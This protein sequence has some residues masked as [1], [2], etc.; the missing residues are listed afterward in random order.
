M[1]GANVAIGGKSSAVFYNPAGLAH[2]PKQ[3]GWE[4]GLVNL[5]LSWNENIAGSPGDMLDCVNQA[6]ANA[7]AEGCKGFL[8]E[9]A[10]AATTEKDSN[11][12]VISTGQKS[13]NVID[14][15]DQYLGQN[16]Y[17]ELNEF[18]SVAKKFDKLGFA[19]GAVGGATMSFEV[20]RGFGSDGVM[21]VESL[22]YGGG[23]L[24]ASYDFSAVEVG[25]IILN[26]FSLGLG[27]KS[28]QYGSI[29]HAFLISELVDD[30]LVDRLDPLNGDLVKLGQSTVVDLGLTYELMPNVNVGAS[31][32]NM[33]GIGDPD[34]VYIPMTV[35]FGL[36]YVY[37]RPDAYFFDRIRVAADY[38]DLTG[39]YDTDSD[40]VKRTRIGV[41]SYVW[42]SFLTA[43]ALRAGM[44]QGEYTAGFDFRLSFLQLGF[45]TY[46]EQVGAA[47]AT[48]IDR[49]YIMNL[50]LGW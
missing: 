18:S 17:F 15:I 45:A 2:I 14:V 24:G 41:E 28:I 49:R 50:S 26:D 44:Y 35:N 1:G 11:G 27:V 8:G 23:V 32:M 34:G 36:G 47:Y 16:F 12:N 39:G 13:A 3:W 38:V 37:E 43:L 20:H 6:T 7:N 48:D 22:G 5:N 30:K 10:S 21:E 29:T 46:A 19:V 40:I 4:F 9:M 25:N 33:G 31:V 42:D